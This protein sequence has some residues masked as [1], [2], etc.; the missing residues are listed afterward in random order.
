MPCRA[1]KE[2][3]V[4]EGE[5]VVDGLDE[6]A[7]LGL[8]LG[9]GLELALTLTLTLTLILTLTLTLTLILILTLTL[10]KPFSGEG[11]SM[12]DDSAPSTA[13]SV[14]AVRVSG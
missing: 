14:G 6:E 3:D 1:E 11:Q 7:W 10:S 5:R 8:G 12:R 2:Q 9:L 13:T 4:D